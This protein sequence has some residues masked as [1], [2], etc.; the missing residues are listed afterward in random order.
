M[1][2]NHAE[3]ITRCL[4]GIETQQTNFNFEVIIGDDFSTDNNISLIK[5]FIASSTNKNINYILLDRKKGDEYDINRQKKGR[6]YNFTN[7]IENCSGKYIALLD[8][9]DYWTDTDKLQ[10]QVNI[11]EKH[12]SVSLVYTNA[13]VISDHKGDYVA[14]DFFYSENYPSTPIKS[15]VFF[16]ENNF[17]L[18]SVSIMFRKEFLGAKELELIR[19]FAVGDLPLHFILSGKGDFY[20]INEPMVVYNDHGQGISKT[21]DK[22]KRNLLNYKQM[23]LLLPYIKKENSKWFNYFCDTYLIKPIF[24]AFFKETINKKNSTVSLKQLFFINWKHLNLRY[25]YY[26]LKLIIFKLKQ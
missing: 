7:I 22:L 9:D 16:L 14:D 8:G 3:Y 13:K 23:N 2:Y 10:K 6:L 25:C 20:Y 17:A 12:A 19:K 21:F 5:Q 26:I 18:L 1:T 4:E 11:L 15:Q 24:K